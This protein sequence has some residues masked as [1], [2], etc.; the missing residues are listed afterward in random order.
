M[1]I[2]L[3]TYFDNFFFSNNSVYKLEK[4]KNLSEF[5]SSV[6]MKFLVLLLAVVAIAQVSKILNEK[7]VINLIIFYFT[8]LF[9]K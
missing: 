7:C 1:K 3:I 4:V 5:N 2:T 6:I 8:I 9:D